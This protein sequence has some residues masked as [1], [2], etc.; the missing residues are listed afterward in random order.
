[1]SRIVPRHYVRCAS[2]SGDGGSSSFDE[3]SLSD[4]CASS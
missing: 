4:V 1:M 3:A 2:S